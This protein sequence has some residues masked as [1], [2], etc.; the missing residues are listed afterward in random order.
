[1]KIQSNNTQIENNQIAHQLSEISTT[2]HQLSSNHQ[3]SSP[4]FELKPTPDIFEQFKIIETPLQQGKSLRNT[5]FCQVFTGHKNN[6][7][8]S[9]EMLQE[10]RTARDLCQKLATPEQHGFVSS[11]EMHTLGESAAQILDNLRQ[12]LPGNQPMLDATSRATQQ[13]SDL[14]RMARCE[15][16]DA[17]ANPQRESLFPGLNELAKRC[18]E[19]IGQIALLIAQLR[20]SGGSPVNRQTP[21]TQSSPHDPSSKLREALRVEF[22]GTRGIEE[23]NIS[24]IRIDRKPPT[25]PSDLIKDTAKEPSFWEKVGNFFKKVFKV[26]FKIVDMLSPLL[27]FIPGIGPALF[28]AYQGIKIVASIIQGNTGNIVGSIAS[29]LGSI[30][31]PLG[32]AVGGAAGTAAGN[33]IKLISQ[34]AS[35]AVSIGQSIMNAA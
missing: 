18:A 6:L 33:A 7:A 20:A 4:S 29:A 27:N 28:A 16:I 21:S 24:N 26:L 34:A 14:Q 1:M 9:A 15:L 2:T 23:S 11:Q 8:C 19:I 30:A 31:G 35:S 10:F 3:T 13:L 25:S 17:S 22:C 32:N 12:M 5:A